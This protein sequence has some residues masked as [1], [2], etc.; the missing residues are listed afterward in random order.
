MSYDIRFAVK[1]AD[2]PDDCYAVIGEPEHNNPTY[3][4]RDIFVKAMDWNYTQ[5]KFYPLT[6]VLPKIERGVH[7]LTFNA[8]AYKHLEPDNGW[9]S[10]SSALKALQSVLDYFKKDSFSGHYGSWNA[11]VP[12]ECIYI[13]W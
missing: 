10:V 5:S 11:C 8:K 4:V 1:V 9:G 6:E 13:S 3:N 2:A 7:E 12:L